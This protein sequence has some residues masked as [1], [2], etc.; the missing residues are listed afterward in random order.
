MIHPIG[1]DVYFYRELSRCFPSEQTIIAIR[2]P[3][4]REKFTH[5]DSVENIATDYI[6]F[7]EATGIKP[8]YLLGGASFGGIVA[9][10]MAQQINTKYAY[11]P[12][13]V[14][15][16]SP[17]QGHLPK[18]KSK[19]EILEYLVI[20]LFK[21]TNIGI[22]ELNSQIGLDNKIALITERLKL[23]NWSV[24]FSKHLL[25]IT[26]DVWQIHGLCM[27]KYYPN[28]YPGYVIFFSPQEGTISEQQAKYWRGLVHGAFHSFVVPGNHISMNASPNVSR[29]AEILLSLNALNQMHQKKGMVQIQ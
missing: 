20:E 19:K 24:P 14:M 9:F 22:E 1:G 5:Y 4:L 29:V 25:H 18:R 2:S 13:I 23:R 12:S 11:T 3:L 28:P 26:L 17:S 27:E 10:E 8:P 7:L 21:D 15:M 6:G 16:D